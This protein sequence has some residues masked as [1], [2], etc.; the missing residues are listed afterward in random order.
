MYGPC[1][2]CSKFSS[3]I[4]NVSLGQFHSRIFVEDS[5]AGKCIPLI[6]GRGLNGREKIHALE[7]LNL[8]HDQLNA[9]YLRVL[10][11]FI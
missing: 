8:L 9:I 4:C 2:V 11:S 3:H 6:P 7:A 10:N 5:R 1:Y